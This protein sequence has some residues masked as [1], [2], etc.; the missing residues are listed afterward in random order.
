MFCKS[1][2]NAQDTLSIR[3]VLLDN[4][5]VKG[6]RSSPVKETA[7]GSMLWEMTSMN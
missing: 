4:I 5:V 7:D 2:V 3:N 6:Y 1:G